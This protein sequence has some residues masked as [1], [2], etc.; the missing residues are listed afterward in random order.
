M[1]NRTYKYFSGKPLYGFGF[2]LSYTKFAYSGLKLPTSVKA[3]A[4]AAI[5]VDVN[6]SG[7]IAGD[8]V[9]ELYLS[10]P[11][12]FETPIR[13]LAAFKRIHLDPNEST[14]VSL[15]IN[16]RSLGQVDAKGNRVI[17]PGEYTVSVGSTQ[18]GETEAVQTGKFLI[19]GQAT[20]PK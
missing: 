3:G 11:K 14:H 10:Q 12:G 6:N 17:V 18:P 16:P 8:E 7:A 19:K 1:K 5:E 2:G 9:V 20:L 15:T 4:P 13:E